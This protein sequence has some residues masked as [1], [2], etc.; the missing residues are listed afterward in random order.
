MRRQG[1]RISFFEFPEDEKEKQVIAAGQFF[2]KSTVL[3]EDD[4]PL[5]GIACQFGDIFFFKQCASTQPHPLIHM[6]GNTGCHRHTKTQK[7]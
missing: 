2:Q 7:E 3:L 5:P 4:S 1:G 6:F